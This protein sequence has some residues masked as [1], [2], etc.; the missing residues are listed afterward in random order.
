LKVAKQPILLQ[1]QERNHS[2]NARKMA[3]TDASDVPHSRS[4]QSKELDVISGIIDAN[5]LICEHILQD[6]IRGKSE[7]QRAGA[8]GMS[9]EQVLRCIIV[10]ILFGFTYDGLSTPF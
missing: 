9:A 8:N 6:L 7:A 2:Q 4:S 3:K 5:P 10:K 1:K